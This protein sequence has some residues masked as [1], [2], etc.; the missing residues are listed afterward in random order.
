MMPALSR[1]RM[2]ITLGRALD[3]R[4]HWPSIST[5]PSVSNVTWQARV[6]IGDEV[7]WLGVEFAGHRAGHQAQEGLPFDGVIDSPSIRV[8]C[9]TGVEWGGTPRADAL[10]AQGAR[11]AARRQNPS[12]EVLR[13]LDRETISA[14]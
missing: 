14:G 4:C 8:V 7:E 3:G 2:T 11:S 13:P 9:R 12:D 6:A 5:T 10:L 1:I